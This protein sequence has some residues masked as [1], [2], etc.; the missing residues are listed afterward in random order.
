MILPWTLET[1]PT[2][3]LPVVDSRMG[4]SF[5]D[6]TGRLGLHLPRSM[7]HE[8]KRCSLAR[9][10]NCFARNTITHR[11]LGISGVDSFRFSA[12]VC[13][14]V[15]NHRRTSSMIH[16]QGSNQWEQGRKRLND[17]RKIRGPNFQRGILLMG[18]IF[19]LNKRLNCKFYS[20]VRLIYTTVSS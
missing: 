18:G 9:T 3:F 6:E 17:E 20:V 1:S 7:R 2:A 16:G 12:L 14:I 4:Q 13:N 5:I 8:G 19:F 10:R 11:G 15:S